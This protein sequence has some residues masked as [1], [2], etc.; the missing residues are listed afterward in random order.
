ML[1]L[2]KM[3][4]CS[5]SWPRQRWG[6]RFPTGQLP[7][8]A[9]CLCPAQPDGLDPLCL[10][11]PGAEDTQTPSRSFSL[12]SREMPHP[13]ISSWGYVHSPEVSHSVPRLSDASVHAGALPRRRGAQVGKAG[14]GMGQPRQKWGRSTGG[15]SCSATSLLIVHC[16]LL[17]EWSQHGDRRR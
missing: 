11:P 5:R 10:L 12:P 3:Q 1:P 6:L 8:V 9:S 2:M 13:S 7:Q 16:S 15:E 4:L 17:A 14:I